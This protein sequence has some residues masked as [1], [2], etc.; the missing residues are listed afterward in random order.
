MLAWFKSI[1]LS[2]YY[3]RI[4]ASFILQDTLNINT[5]AIKHLLKEAQWTP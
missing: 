4:S 3:P 2:S 5:E 1:S